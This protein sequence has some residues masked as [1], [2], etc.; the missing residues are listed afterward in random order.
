MAAKGDDLKVCLGCRSASKLLRVASRL[1]FLVGPIG[2]GG[3]AVIAVQALVMFAALAAPWQF[4][5]GMTAR[6]QAGHTASDLSRPGASRGRSQ[7]SS[8]ADD[9]PVGYQYTIGSTDPAQK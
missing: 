3:G 9:E 7:R 5:G 2:G 8:R 1:V 4:T 6:R